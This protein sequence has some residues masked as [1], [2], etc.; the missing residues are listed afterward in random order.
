MTGFQ[1][2]RLADDMDQRL[3]R[4]VFVHQLD[5]VVIYNTQIGVKDTK[6]MNDPVRQRL[7]YACSYAKCKHIHAGSLSKLPDRATLPKQSAAH[8]CKSSRSDSLSQVRNLS[9]TSLLLNTGTMFS[10]IDIIKMDVC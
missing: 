8:V 10:S 4:M 3:N 2:S 7:V 6:H 1:V 5:A 9:M